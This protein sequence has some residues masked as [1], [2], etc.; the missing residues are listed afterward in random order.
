MNIIS[1]SEIIQAIV[2]TALAVVVVRHNLQDSK[3]EKIQK[4]KNIEEEKLEVLKKAKAAAEEI[5]LVNRALTL[6]PDIHAS[7][8][9]LKTIYNWNQISE[10]IG[11]YSL[12]QMLLNE[13]DED[14]ELKL[15]DM[16]NQN[17]GIDE[18]RVYRNA[19]KHFHPILDHSLEDVYQEPTIETLN[20]LESK[21]FI[22]V[23][24]PYDKKSGVRT[25]SI[26]AHGIRFRKISWNYR[27]VSSPRLTK[28][29]SRE[30]RDV[31]SAILYKALSYDGN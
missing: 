17:Y 9:L 20:D 15:P 19:K 31:I 2:F 30:A 3:A 12:H 16:R 5:E 26:T 22:L 6:L 28:Y 7:M 11:M 18:K 29:P 23:D 4:E 14:T 8:S 27:D 21:G 25:A 10:T 24:K 1:G 13:I